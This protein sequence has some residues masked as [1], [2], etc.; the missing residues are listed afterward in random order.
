[1]IFTIRSCQAVQRR[2]ITLVK[3]E[4]FFPHEVLTT[5]DLSFQQGERNVVV[6][7]MPP[8]LPEESSFCLEPPSKRLAF[9]R[10]A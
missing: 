5:L 4:S 6:D 8:A 1:M 9:F 7:F 10:L 2:V 3:R